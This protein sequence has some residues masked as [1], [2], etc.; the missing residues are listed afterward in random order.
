MKNFLL[1][2]LLFFCSTFSFGQNVFHS[3]DSKEKLESHVKIIIDDFDFF[4]KE[5]GVEAPYKPGVYIHT[6]PFLIKWDG[7]NKRIILPYWDE[8]LDEQKE[9]FKTWKGEEAEE[10]FISLFN[11]FFIPHELGHFV[12]MNFNSDTLT[13]YEFELAA[14][15][16]AIAFLTRKEENMDKI[17]YI[18]KSLSDVLKI[19]P[20]IDFGD[21]TEVEYFN[22]NY[23]QLGNNP[24]IY[25]YFQFK[26]ILDLL[27]N[28][29]KI[30]LQKYCK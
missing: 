5:M 18:R 27:N 26:F 29:E 19:L 28:Q 24:N 17:K 13:P 4:L 6:A 25:G 12:E 8:L 10:L 14:N 20:K 15:E 3:Y 11:W 16:F 23:K 30:N 9:I 22:T 2:I 1:S 21:L 7:Q